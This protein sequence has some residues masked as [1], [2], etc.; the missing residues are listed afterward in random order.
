MRLPSEIHGTRE[1]RVAQ[2]KNDAELMGV[3]TKLV[4]EVIEKAKVEAMRRRKVSSV[5]A[6]RSSRTSAAVRLLKNKTENLLNIERINNLQVVLG[7]SC[8]GTG[9]EGG[10]RMESLKEGVPLFKADTRVEERRR[11]GWG[12]RT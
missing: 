5:L 3:A 4:S 1:E 9:R 12:V 2:F 10:G 6:G 8:K 11:E 7:W